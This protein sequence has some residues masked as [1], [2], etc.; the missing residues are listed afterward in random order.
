MKLGQTEQFFIGVINSP[1]IY[2]SITLQA[3]QSHAIKINK[4]SFH[5]NASMSF[6]V[7]VSFHSRALS[8]PNKHKAKLEGIS[9][10]TYMTEKSNCA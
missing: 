3:L 9:V 2:D 1:I 5:G 6:E 7:L 8:I 4:L 10:T